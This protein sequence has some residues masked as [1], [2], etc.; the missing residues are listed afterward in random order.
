[1]KKRNKLWILQLLIIIAV[2]AIFL[3]WDKIN[4]QGE[5]PV[6]SFDQEL[7]EVS[8]SASEADLLNGVSAY[9]EED[10]DIT[11]EI[12]VDSLSAFDA[13]ENRVVTYAVF[14][15][16]CN[17]TKATRLIHYVD[18]TK[19]RFSLLKSFSSNT[20]NVTNITNM[21][22]ATSCVDGDI[23]SRISVE[24][25]TSTTSNIINFVATVSDSTG[26]TSSIEL[27]YNYDTNNY[28]TS[29]ELNKYLVYQ[30][31]GEGF[32]A[33]ANIAN[34]ETRSISTNQRQYLN[35]TENVNY[36]VPGV[37]EITYTFNY[38]GDYGFAKCVVVVE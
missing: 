19:P 24:A 28:T 8:V 3:V 18:Y 32:D 26:E 17:V 9:D 7:V 10:G 23:T 35:I 38:Y 5:A 1:M 22:T 36:N 29:I 25:K 15:S 20:L 12:V 4:D 21:I 37:Y 27:K 33:N 11:S 2:Y 6:I 30:K 14:D 31:V 16:D 34:I 13:N